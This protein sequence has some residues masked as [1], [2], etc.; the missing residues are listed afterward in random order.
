MCFHVFF[1]HSAQW[2]LCLAVFWHVF[3]TADLILMKNCQV[4]LIFVYVDP[5]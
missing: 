3:I 2:S 1:A 4:I 5:F